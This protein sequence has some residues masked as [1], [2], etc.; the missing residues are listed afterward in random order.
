MSVEEIKKLATQRG[1][2]SPEIKPHEIS[3]V[4]ESVPKPQTEPTFT[5]LAEISKMSSDE[6]ARLCL[7]SPSSQAWCSYL[8]SVLEGRVVDP[9]SVGLPDFLVDL[10][11]LVYNLLPKPPEALKKIVLSRVKREIE[12]LAR[13]SV[14]KFGD[15]LREMASGRVKKA[16]GEAEELVKKIVSATKEMKLQPQ[17]VLGEVGRVVAKEFEGK[18]KTLK[19]EEVVKAFT[20]TMSKGAVA[21]VELARKAVVPAGEVKAGATE[22][23]AMSN[24]SSA[25]EVEEKLAKKAYVRL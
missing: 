9:P 12:K 15:V 20:E 21:I 16:V 4:K 25:T 23:K 24:S 2:S 18:V 22:I 5:K 7:Q 13:E 10:V 11:V 14:E 8:E 3:S 6:L 19:P 1:V 17:V